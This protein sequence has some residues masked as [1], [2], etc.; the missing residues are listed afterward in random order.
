MVEIEGKNISIT[1]GDML[2]LVVSIDNEEN[3][4]KDEF[5]IDDIIR[6]KIMQKDKVENVILEK[7]FKIEEVSTEKEIVITSSEMKIGELKSK[8]VDYWYEIE[9]NPDTE[10]TNTIV[11]YSKIDGPAIL[12]IL[13][14][15]GNKENEEDNTQEEEI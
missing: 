8:P 10:K 9:L 4:E 3:E 13:P 7:D 2:A 11:G 5:Q 12:T 1:R 6:F 14:E 15:G